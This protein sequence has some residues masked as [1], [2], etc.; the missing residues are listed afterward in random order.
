MERFRRWVVV[1]TV[2]AAVPTALWA[3]E[4]AGTRAFPSLNIAVG[5]QPVAMGEAGVAL[6]EDAYAPFWNPAGLAH[7]ERAQIA[8]FNNAWLLDLRQNGGALVRPLGASAG[9]S[10]HLTYLDYGELVRRDES[11]AETGLFRPYDLTAGLGLG[12]RVSDR[13]AVGLVGKYL[14]Q[15]IDTAKADAFAVDLG[16]RADLPDR[17]LAFGA[18]LQHL[19]SALRFDGKSYSLASA[20]R[21]GVGYRAW[22]DRAAGALDLLFPFGDDPQLSVGLSYLLG[23]RLSLRAGY[24]YTIGGNDLGAVSGITAG[25]GL[26]LETL[27][28]DY[29]F[30]SYGELGPTNRVSLGLVF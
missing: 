19:G 28:V 2:W 15:Q 16:L 11:G 13:L 25:F 24:R 27:V 22:E 21:V 6:V 1:W 14:R 18:A 10:A 8:L 20:L 29:A 3:A 12:F 9:I 23:G 26:L 17:G 4:G 30:V 5:A 7:V